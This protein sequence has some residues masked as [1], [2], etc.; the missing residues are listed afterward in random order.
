M[1]G[2]HITEF[3]AMALDQYGNE[4]GLPTELI[5][6]QNVAVGAGSVQSA[7]FDDRTRIVRLVTTAACH[8]AIGANPVA[9]T[10]TEYL[11]TSVIDYRHVRGGDKIAAKN[12]S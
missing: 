7:A 3:A 8:F 4:T 2:L 12:T 10:A 1:A 5:G 6:Y 9:S 11:P